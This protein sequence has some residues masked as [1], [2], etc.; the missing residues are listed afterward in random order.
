MVSQ[1]P[2]MV[3][4][5]I[6]GSLERFFGVLIENCAGDFPLWLSPVSVCVVVHVLA[7]LFTQNAKFRFNC[8]YFPSLSLQ[9]RIAMKSL[10][11]LG[12]WVFE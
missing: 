2:I 7:L 4:R 5:A 1:R 6:L 11:T 12:L 8:C 3:H 9:F 10:L